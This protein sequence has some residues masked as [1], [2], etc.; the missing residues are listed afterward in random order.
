MSGDQDRGVDGTG[1]HGMPR[2][3]ME[4]NGMAM[5]RAAVRRRSTFVRLGPLVDR[6]VL[7][8]VVV[9]V[10]VSWSCHVVYSNN[11]PSL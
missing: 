6:R 10:I 8:V 7:V 1:C 3:G 5:D 4:G 9:V 11:L 2:D